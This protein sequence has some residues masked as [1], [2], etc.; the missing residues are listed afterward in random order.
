MTKEDHPLRG[1]ETFLGG[2]GIRPTHI[3]DPFFPCLI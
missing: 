1:N 3:L 2:P